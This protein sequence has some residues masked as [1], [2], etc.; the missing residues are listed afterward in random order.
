[1][2]KYTCMAGLVAML[3]MTACSAQT[4]FSQ[5]GNAHFAASSWQT[6][7]PARASMLADLVTQQ[8]VMGKSQAEVIALLGPADGYYEYDEFPAYRLREDKECVVGF[9]LD[10]K[11]A[12]VDAVVIFPEGCLDQ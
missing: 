9:S 11:T 2:N 1:M 8:H 10:R 4:D 5:Y 6:S 7:I 12:K 3:G